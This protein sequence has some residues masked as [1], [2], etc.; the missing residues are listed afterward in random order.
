MRHTAIR[1]SDSYKLSQARRSDL[2]QRTHIFGAAQVSPDEMGGYFDFSDWRGHAISR[3]YFLGRW[4]FLYF[5]YSR[6][7]GSCRIAAPV[8]TQAAASL[9]ARKF[10]ARA[11]FVDIEAQPVRTPRSIIAEEG[12][13]DHGLNWPMRFAMARLFEDQGGG[14]DVLTGN[15]AQLARSTTAFHVLREHVPPRS[16]ESGSSINHSSMIYLIGPDTL[17]AGYCYHDVGADTLVSLVQELDKAER[18]DIDF[19]AIKRRYLLG[20]CGEE[21]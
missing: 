20:A 21:A 9:R 7:K 14:L 1:I 10:S 19:S 6:C 18:E 4:T 11:A 2:A 15:R 3:D 13:H 16:D 12:G 17:V 5:G 8:I